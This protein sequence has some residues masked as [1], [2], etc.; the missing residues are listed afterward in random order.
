MPGED[1]DRPMLQAIRDYC[2]AHAAAERGGEGAAPTPEAQ[3]R[4]RAYARV[5]R[6]AGELLEEMEG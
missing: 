2:S 5:A 3:A 1:D 6:A 4:R